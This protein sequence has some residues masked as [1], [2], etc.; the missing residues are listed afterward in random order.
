MS[1]RTAKLWLQLLIACMCTVLAVMGCSDMD[2]A[3]IA[4]WPMPMWIRVLVFVSIAIAAILAA[5]ALGLI[6]EIMY[7][8]IPRRAPVVNVLR[9]LR[10]T[11]GVALAYECVA[12][13]TFVIGTGLANFAFILLIVFSVGLLAA[14]FGFVTTCLRTERAGSLA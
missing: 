4:E 13:A 3:F 14:A 12:V 6:V 1:S 11:L 9:H 10:N 8:L 5:I 2:Q 7:R